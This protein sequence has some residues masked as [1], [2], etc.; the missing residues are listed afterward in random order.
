MPSGLVAP[1]RVPRPRSRRDVALLLLLLSVVVS[2]A[3]LLTLNAQ[4]SNAP[5]RRAATGIPASSSAG[6]SEIQGSTAAR[7]DARLI[8][9]EMGPTTVTFQQ[10]VGGYTGAVDTF[11]ASANPTAANSTATPITVDGSPLQHV[12]IRFDDIIGNGV[13]QIPPN[14]TILSASLTVSVTNASANPAAFHRMIQ[15]WSNA[16]T[17]DSLVG[18]V[19]ADGIEA[20]ATADLTGS[21][22]ATG[23]FSIA[24]TPSLAAWSAGATNRGW[25]LLPGGTDGWGFESSEAATMANRPSLAVTFTTDHAPDPPFSES[26]A[27]GATGVSTN[28]TLCAEVSDPDG[29]TL[30]VTFK[31]RPTGQPAPQDFTIIALPDTQFYA[32]SYPATFSAQTQWCVDNRLTRN[33]AFVTQLGDCTNDGNTIPAQWTNANAAFGLLEDSFTTGLTN[34]IPYGIAVGNHDQTPIGTARSGA[35]EGTAFGGAGGTFGGTT[36]YYNQTFGAFRFQGRGYFGDN[37]D[38]GVPGQYS[39]SMDNH[40]EL[41]SA[42]GMNFIA[43]HLE[44]DDVDNPTRQAVLSWVHTLLSTTYSNRRAMIT[45]HY[46]LNPNGTFS[47]QGQATFNAIKDL[48]NVFLMLA[49]HLDQAS[50]RTDLADDGHPIHTLMSDYQTRPNGGDGWLRIMTFSPASDSIHVQTYSPTLGQ[51]INSHPDNTAGTAQNDFVLAYDMDSGTPFSTIGTVSPVT[52]GGQAC[53]SWPGRATGQEY[54]WFA[55]VSDGELTTA[56]PLWTFT[57][58][59]GSNAQCDDAIACTVDTCSGGSC[60]HSPIAGCCATNADCADADPCTNDAC[61]LSNNACDNTPIDCND[62]RACT[63]PDACVGGVCQNPYTP[64]AGCCVTPADCNDGNATTTDICS[65]GTCSNV[66]TSCLTNPDCND[67]DPCTTDSCT[68]A[69]LRSLV[70]DGADDYATMGA[71]AGLNAS[72]AFTVEAWINGVGGTTL[73]T[74]TGTQGFAANTVVPLVAKGRAEQETPANLNMNYFLGIFDPASTRSLAADFEDSATGLNHPVCTTTSLPTTGWHHVAAT[75]SPAGGWSLYVDGVAQALTTTCTTCTGGN[76]TI[77]PG[78]SPEPNSIQHFAIGT[79]MNSTGVSE[80]RYA[81]KMDEIRVWNVER[82]ATDIADARDELITAAPNLIGHY[83]FDDSTATDST[84][85]AEN[86]TLVG[87]PVFDSADRPSVGGACVYVPLSCDDGDPCTAD[88]CSAGGCLHTPAN[89]GGACNDGNGCTTDDICTSGVCG[90]TLS[91]D[92]GNACTGTDQ[93]VAGSCQHP[94]NPTPGCCTTAADCDDGNPGTADSCSNGNCSNANLVCASGADC[95]D[96]N[97]CTADTCVSG[98]VAALSFDGTDDFVTMGPAAGTGA[99]GA[100]TFTVETWFKWTGGGATVSTGTGGIAAFIPLVTKGAAQAET[101][102]NVNANYLLGIAGGRLA[103]DFED[104]AT[105]LNHPVCT[106]AAQ[107]TITTNVWHH[108]AATYNGT[109]WAL[110]LDGAALPIDTAC[111][112]CAGGACTV[113]P[114]A[115]PESTSIQ[116][117]GLGTTLTSTGTAA[118]FYQGRLDEVRVWN[119]A[120]SQ[121][122]IQAGQFQEVSTAANL[123]GRWGLNDNGPATAADST[124][125]AENGALTNG[126]AWSPTDKAPLTSGTCSYTPIP[127]CVSCSTAADC[128]D[129]NTCTTDACVNGACVNTPVVCGDD[130][131]ACNGPEACNPST[132]LCES[133]P[134]AANGT[135][136]ADANVCNGAETCQAGACVAGTS[137]ACADGNACTNDSCNPATGCVYTNNT[138]PCTEDGN[139]CTDDVCS[140]GS[141]THQNDDSNTCA[142][143]SACTGDACVGGA[144]LSWYAPTPACCNSNADCNDGVAATA[145][146]CSGAPGG[147]CSNVVTGTCSANADCNDSNGCTTDVCNTPNVSALNFDGTNDYV[148]MGPA[149]GTGALGAT[150]FTLET[151][152]KWTGGGT[153]VTTGGGGIAAFIPLVTKGAAQ[154]ESPLNVNA[155]YLL[156]IAGGRLAGDF[157][158]SATGLNHPVCTAATQPTISTN[159]WHHA[160]ATYNGTCWALYLDG[161]ALPIDTACSVCAGGACTVCPSATP[162]STSIQHFGLGTTL[163]ST[164]TA[165]GFYQGRLDE[166]RVWNVARSQAQIQASQFQEVSTAANLIGRWGLNDNGPATAADSTTPAE[167]GTLTNGPAWS[168]ADKA[169]VPPGT[170]SNTPIPNCA[171]CTADYQCNDS[172]S[173]TTDSCNTTDDAAVSFPSPGA[174]A[175]HVDL[176][177][178]SGSA[179]SPDYVNYFGTGSFTIEGWVYTDG[180]AASLT[181]IFRGGQQGAF[182]QVAVQLTGTGNLQL[183]GSVETNTSGTQVDVTHATAL[184]AN[185]WAHFAFVVDRTPGNQQLRLHLNGGAPATAVANLLGTSPVSFTSQSMIGAGRLDTGAVGLPFDGRLDEIRIWNYARTQTETTADMGREIGSAPGLVHR[186]SFNEGSLTTAA[187]SAGGITGTL[188]GATTW[189]TTGLPFAGSDT[190]THTTLA[191]GTVCSDGNACTQ[192][193]SCQSGACTG[194]NTVSCT[195]S[196][197][198]HDAG[199]CSPTTGLCSDPAKPNGTTCSDGNACTQ[200]DSCQSGACT[201]SNTVSCTASDQCHDAGTCDTA[202]GLCSDPA[203]PNGA[204]CSDGNACTTTDACTNGACVAGPAADC[205]DN[206]VCTDDSCDPAVGCRHS[207]NTASCDDGDVCNGTGVC[208]DGAC[209]GTPPPNCDDGNPCTT[210][211]C[212]PVLGCR[213]VNNTA[214]CDDGNACTVGDVC[215]DGACVSGG[216]VACTASDQCHDAGTCDTATGICSNPARPNGSACSDGNA[217]TQTDTCQSGVCTGSNTVTCTASDQCHDAGTCDTATGICS[218]PARPDGSACSDGNACTQTDTC[219]AGACSGANPVVCTASDQCHDAGTCNT[220]TGAC[221]DPAKPNGAACSDGNACTLTDTCQTGTCTSGSAVVCVASD[222]CHVPGVCSPASGVCSNPAKPDGSA[223]DDGNACTAG[224]TCISGSCTPGATPPEVCNGVDDN[225]NSQVDE[226]NPGGGVACST[227]LPGVCAAGITQCSGGTVVCVGTTSPATPNVV[228]QLDTSMKYIANGSTTAAEDSVLVQIDSPMRYLANSADPGI[229]LTWTNESFVEGAGWASGTYGVGYDNATPP[230]ALG[231]IKTSVPAGVFSV[232]TRATFTLTDVSTVKS[233]FYGADYDDGYVAYLN[234]VEVARSSTMPAGSPAWNTDA[235]LHESSNAAAPNYGTLIDLTGSISLLHNGTNVLAVGVWNSA[236]ATSTDLVVVPKLSIG[237]DWTARTFD[238]SAWSTG[239]YG[240]GYDTAAAPNALNLIKT[241]VPAGTLSVFTRAHFNIPDAAAL[242]A[243]QSVTLGVDYDDGTVAWI[244]GVE[245]LGSPEMP[246]GPLTTTTPATEHESSNAAV[247][248]Y[249]PIRDITARALAALVV[250]DNVL[251]IGVWNVLSTSTDLVLVPRLS[252]GEAER[253][254]GLDNDCNGVVDDG[255]ADSDHDGRADCSDTDDDGDGAVDGQ[256]CKPNDAL[257]SAAPPAE[258]LGLIFERAP[259]RSFVLTWTGQGE[260]LHYDVAGGLLSQLVSDHG[261]LNATCVPGGNDLVNASF[262]D[263]RPAPPRGDAYYYIVRSQSSFCGSGTYGRA[264]SGAEYLP[265]SACP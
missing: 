92:D 64:F 103:G 167:N 83:G 154:A 254:D 191:N 223:C 61:D 146:S 172:N 68:A 182:P 215:G 33:I 119:V 102:L 260:G 80:G 62:G 179:A 234:G 123:I 212:D 188:T 226:G 166:V 144:C 244:N 65:S 211:S 95:N 197:Q 210:D 49:G 76:C 131:N 250:G 176:A 75:Y 87:S 137:L 127:G 126:P 71:A 39:D 104:A 111:S 25:V 117:F 115:T 88:S 185:T 107:P 77:T 133:G 235:A 242:A 195:A 94:Y 193:D 237:L 199:T 66:N 155:N 29:D 245:V 243:I 84:A 169:P 240:V 251:A 12:L 159:V 105:G 93:C 203:R 239:T 174:A 262:A 54:E 134:A 121:A 89:D 46:L 120:R 108:A 6:T 184:T 158:D 161:V 70:L 32:Q 26:P 208:Q 97:G 48:P 60:L 37:Y 198:C 55:E 15:A 57:A 30:S 106:A 224:D 150:A 200:T 9:P 163:T 124:T 81:G 136:C 259:D 220:S 217:C 99:L 255:F 221:S 72:P 236:A 79:A 50:R 3:I 45:S 207:N 24:V 139:P 40:F 10:G 91:C 173:C 110:Y 129:A 230:N 96:S 109:C 43:F 206:N 225:C 183:A 21:S 241:S 86:G 175:N 232:F 17:W 142:D 178:G 148:T 22:S 248:N 74:G 256:D 125:P 187:D 152:F 67:S 246:F 156:G 5:D 258:V 59:C 14:A 36:Q 1:L 247:P 38:F 177:L 231:L 229:G 196:D 186:W 52:S 192:T 218:N 44:W 238:D 4:A 63:G 164:G 160:A 42:S 112:S 69:N 8:R 132:G 58:S 20:V 7:I 145:D 180:G 78:A 101:P 13:G 53:A 90:G 265:A 168:P 138:A 147:T 140:G 118:G 194:S 214:P 73:P 2:A 28:P 171:S 34:G 41:F 205:N 18:G 216:P 23:T 149:A 204:A 165:A 257:F 228:T 135:S 141:C 263:T 213:H 157:E 162:E 19:Q 264:S 190:C 209:A 181:G 252:L 249:S 219:Q 122:Q 11:V 85:P 153:P 151:W 170:C 27:T 130:G 143:A 261:A 227:G 47:N 114:S 222:Q 116:H 202:T 201:G 35:N 100:T 56:G 128:N 31:G 233:L 51:F 113:C 16:S 253:C 98:N 82:S 189:S